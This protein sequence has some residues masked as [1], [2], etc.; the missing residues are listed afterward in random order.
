[1]GCWGKTANVRCWHNPLM[2]SLDGMAT[3]GP[4]AAAACGH[5]SAM[6]CSLRSLRRG[7]PPVPATCSL[8]GITLFWVA[9][10]SRTLCLQG[11]QANHR[12]ARA[13]AQTFSPFQDADQGHRARAPRGT[14][15]GPDLRFD[16]GWK[17][18]FLA[19]TH[20]W[21]AW[22]SLKRRG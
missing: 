15:P 16:N 19:C 20:P 17:F 21:F 11:R 3:C 12:F 10:G 5:H 22:R 6:Q 2:G 13:S 4:A 9:S 8:V 7:H 14:W 18:G 1:M